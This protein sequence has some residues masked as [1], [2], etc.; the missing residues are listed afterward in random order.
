MSA[1]EP[2]IRR[3]RPGDARALAALA[4]RTFEETFGRD[5]TPED[6][7]AHL[8][9][10]YGEAQQGAELASPDVVT[11]V[12]EREGELVA[13]AQVR[14]ASETPACVMAR[15]PVELW[16]FYVA[17]AWQG[18]GVAGP[19]ML[20]ALQAARDLGGASVWLSVWERNP[21]A[22]AFYAKCGFLDVGTKEFVVGSDRQTDRVLLTRLDSSTVRPS[23]ASLGTRDAQ[24]PPGDD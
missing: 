10:S 1:G 3:G 9:R 21:R 20:A 4:A 22:I 13:Y 17:R 16:R 8:E 5:N 11:L 7:A 19:L 14:R 12:A 23:A 15:E 2:T 18:R 24:H 6:M